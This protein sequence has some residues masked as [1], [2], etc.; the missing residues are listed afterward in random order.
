[1]KLKSSPAPHIRFQESNQTMMFDIIL[2]LAVL[3]SLAFVFYGIRVLLVC[4]ASVAAAVLSD[5]ICVLLRRRKPNP[6]DLSPVV[7][8]LLIALAMPATIAYTPV[9]AA[10]IFAMILVKH[11]FGGTGNNLFNPA[12]AGISFAAICWPQQVFSYPLPFDPIALG[13]RYAEKTH[14]FVATITDSLGTREVVSKLYQNPLFTLRLGGV[15]ANDPTEMLLGNFPGAMGA[16]CVI[17]LIACLLYLCFRQTVR[18]QL[19]LGFLAACTGIAYFFPRISVSGLLS[20]QYELMS[21]LLLFGAVFLLGDPVTR[22]KRPVSMLLY[23]IFTGIITMLFRY[24]GGFEES[25][26][27]AILL[28]NAFVPFFDRYD[29][30]MHRLLRRKNRDFSQDQTASDAQPLV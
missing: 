5:S 3:M 10:S 15:P 17:V 21:G 18:W 23:G 1:M 9:I 29:E 25:V 22:P 19:P 8:G 20:V 12:A 16:T 30:N 6:R 7:T 27:F 26:F 28:A 2:L 14:A 4:A 24:Y 13:G 11:P